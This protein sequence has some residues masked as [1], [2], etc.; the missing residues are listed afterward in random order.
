MF[1]ISAQQLK[2]SK[3]AAAMADP[4]GGAFVSF[5][6]WVRNRNDGRDVLFLE[7]ECYETLALK[8]GLRILAEA[9]ARFDVLNV[10]CVHRTGRLDIG[11]L[12][13]WIGVIAEHRGEAFRACQF[14][15]DEVKHR[16]PIW[17]KET[18]ANGASEWVNCA[19][20]AAHHHAEGEAHR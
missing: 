9:A 14:V 17:K 15:I 18:Y 16:V 1:Q 19:G 5:E 11:E 2:A 6:G 7:Y 8:E 20:C 13:V 10:R 12:A 3:L 4:R